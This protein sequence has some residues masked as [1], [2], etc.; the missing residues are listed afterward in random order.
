[1]NE[2]SDTPTARGG[3][4]PAQSTDTALQREAAVT[5]FEH[6]ASRQTCV[7]VP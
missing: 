7:P 2:N 6:G 5:I 3:W 1:M 4:P